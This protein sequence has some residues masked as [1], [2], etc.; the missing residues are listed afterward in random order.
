MAAMTTAAAVEYHRKS[1]WHSLE[2]VDIELE[3]GDLEKASQALW[4]SAAHAVKAAAARRGWKHDSFADLGD[5]I[6]RLINDEGGSTILNTNFIMA[7]SFDRELS[8]EIPLHEAGIRY[9]CDGPIRE[10]LRT[11]ENLPDPQ[12]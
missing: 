3:Q 7:S 8:H 2:R 12:P 11:L 1:S 5:V 4:D 9:C 10:L 6:I